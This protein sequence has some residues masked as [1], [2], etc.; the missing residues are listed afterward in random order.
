MMNREKDTQL[1]EDK[2]LLEDRLREELQR[3][4]GYSIV[5]RVLS[6]LLQAEKEAN[7]GVKKKKGILY[8]QIE[9][10]YI[11]KILYDAF[12]H[13][14]GAGRYGKGPPL[15]HSSPLCCVKR[16]IHIAKGSKELV[17]SWTD[18][19]IPSETA[20]QLISREKDFF[21]FLKI[22]HY[23]KKEPLG[24]EA[25]GAAEGALSPRIV[26]LYDGAT[27]GR[28]GTGQREEE[29][30][31]GRCTDGALAHVENSS[32]A[33]SANTQGVAASCEPHSGS[34]ANAKRKAPPKGDAKKFVDRHLLLVHYRS[35]LKV[36]LSPFLNSLTRATCKHPQIRFDSISTA[37]EEQHRGCDER[38]DGPTLATP[39]GR[40]SKR[41]GAKCT[42]ESSHWGGRRITADLQNGVRGKL[43]QSK[44]DFPPA[45]GYDHPDSHTDGDIANEGD[46]VH[47]WVRPLPGRQTRCLKFC[48]LPKGTNCLEQICHLLPAQT[49]HIHIFTSKIE[50][51]K[52]IFLTF[53][54]MS[55]RFFLF[56][57]PLLGLFNGDH[58]QV[59]CLA[60]DSREC[61]TPKGSTPKGITPKGSTP[62]VITPFL[63]ELS[64]SIR[65]LYSEKKKLIRRLQKY[66]ANRT[67]KGY[68]NF[69]RFDKHPQKEERIYSYTFYDLTDNFFLTMGENSP[70]GVAGGA[71][72]RSPK[73][74]SQG[75]PN[76]LQKIEPI[77]TQ[78]SHFN[79]KVDVH[80]AKRRLEK[81][82]VNVTDVLT[83]CRQFRASIRW[84]KRRECICVYFV[85]KDFPPV[86]SP[87]GSG[88]NGPVVECSKVYSCVPSPLHSSDMNEGTTPQEKNPLQRVQSVYAFQILSPRGRIFKMTRR[89]CSLLFSLAHKMGKFPTLDH[90]H[91]L[92]HVH[93][94][95]G[96]FPYL[97]VCYS[98]EGG[99]IG[100]GTS[101]GGKRDGIGQLSLVHF[102]P[103]MEGL[104][105]LK[106][107]RKKALRRVLLKEGEFP[108]L[109]KMHKLLLFFYLYVLGKMRLTWL[110]RARGSG[111]GK[112]P[113][114]EAVCKEAH[115]EE[116][117][118]PSLLQ[119]RFDEFV[120]QI[121]GEKW[122]E[123]IHLHVRNCVEVLLKRDEKGAHTGE[124]T[125]D[126]SNALEGGA[127]G[128]K[129]TLTNSFISKPV[130]MDEHFLGGAE[131]SPAGG[132]GDREVD[133]EGVLSAGRSTAANVANNDPPLDNHG[134]SHTTQRSGGAHAA[135]DDH[136]NFF[137]LRNMKKTVRILGTAL[138][139]RMAE[140]LY[141]GGALLNVNAHREELLRIVSQFEEDAKGVLCAVRE[142]SSPRGGILTPSQDDRGDPPPSLNGEEVHRLL[143]HICK[144]KR[145]NKKLSIFNIPRWCTGGGKLRHVGRTKVNNKVVRSFFR[146]E[147]S[148][149]EKRLPLEE[150]L[151]R[152]SGSGTY[153]VALKYLVHFVNGHIT[154]GVNIFSKDH[155]Q[156]GHS[157]SRV[158]FLNVCKND[159]IKNML[160]E[161][162]IHFLEDLLT[163]VQENLPFLESERVHAPKGYHFP[164]NVC[165]ICCYELKPGKCEM[166]KM[167]QVQPGGEF[168]VHLFTLTSQATVFLYSTGGG[169]GGGSGGS[170]SGGGRDLCN[171][172]FVKFFQRSKLYDAFVESAHGGT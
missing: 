161:R 45:E 104:Q 58:C 27:P 108:F 131:A 19:G 31:G 66:L 48:R 107:R 10:K 143:H 140:K 59:V 77:L 100:G 54:N 158:Y 163:Y 142:A 159:V 50:R 120:K 126:R 37:T 172:F 55:K 123:K 53:H 15:D 98:Q 16:R 147:K 70:E 136:A 81:V 106:R 1:L 129:G 114:E 149:H 5:Q 111:G 23:V 87:K 8:S 103:Y 113:R 83:W 96:A 67:L 160:I 130:C 121:K 35:H 56:A 139:N 170:G 41:R 105:H 169:S 133:H 36:P 165:K 3:L 145:V 116:T 11:G 144:K 51:E 21:I 156:W 79:P 78:C 148:P 93:H 14:R 89:V 82:C 141:D 162:T 39:H 128:A 17:V 146:L 135:K 24:G 42:S 64:H 61:T 153:K 117:P 157:K 97:Y 63:E 127:R 25:D 91:M 73:N 40:S 57:S 137:K 109:L 95:V 171:P 75:L 65:S 26:F 71:R 74:P 47:S 164:Y 138:M 30:H 69:R 43:C 9:S 72:R 155:Q 85:R 7:G 112:E 168:Y 86:I 110:H 2:R 90:L 84:R 124:E 92:R 118:P 33:L 102:S 12:C 68:L 62:H 99:S 38:G 101:T 60:S 18:G 154:F 166:R 80:F 152:G 44:R 34:A 150:L 115:K 122:K 76:L 32:L 22:I 28:G 132:R 52:E 20:F 29:R 46:M 134:N 6:P 151:Q 13:S 4:R 119:S 88:T 167:Y 94:V 125:S 49:S